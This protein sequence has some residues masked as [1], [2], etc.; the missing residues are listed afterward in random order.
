[1][2]KRSTCLLI[3]MVLAALLAACSSAPGEPEKVSFTIKGQ[4]SFRYDPDTLT[5]PTGASISLTLE[6]AGVLDHSWVLLPNG[7]DPLAANE[8]D[9]LGGASTG[10]L[11]GGQSKTITFAAPPAGTYTFVCTVPGHAAAGKIGALTVEP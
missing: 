11:P 7:T 4:D 9:A 1:M 8:T 6:N 2:M 5:V 10:I 3:V